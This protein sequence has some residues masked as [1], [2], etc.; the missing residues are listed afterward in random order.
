LSK[1]YHTP[2]EDRLPKIRRWLLGV[3]ELDD[4][5][6]SVPISLGDPA[7]AA[8]ASAASVEIK[9][10][11]HG[12][13]GDSPAF[14]V[15]LRFSFRTPGYGLGISDVTLSV[16]FFPCDGGTGDE[17][18]AVVS[19]T[20]LKTWDSPGVRLRF[21]ARVTDKEGNPS[22]ARWRLRHADV[23]ESE[24][25]AIPVAILVSKKSKGTI[26]FDVDAEVSVE[27]RIGNGGTR[28]VG[29]I[30]MPTRRTVVE[31]P[32]DF[33]AMRDFTGISEY[34]MQSMVGAAK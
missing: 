15:M 19:M 5:T 11:V 16:D 17:P 12:K 2:K 10:I 33:G 27:Q 24:W 30:H 22:G 3:H 23:A 18:P 1:L 20:A 32:D 6:E 29:E 14:I 21:A 28:E 8:I 31:P 7:A 34:E 4:T 9:P 26:R 13:M 25:P